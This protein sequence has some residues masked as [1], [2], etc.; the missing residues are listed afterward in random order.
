MHRGEFFLLSVKKKHIILVIQHPIARS[1]PFRHF[2]YVKRHC[3]N[4]NGG[5]GAEKSSGERHRR[6]LTKNG[7]LA[8][9]SAHAKALGDFV[10]A[11]GGRRRLRRFDLRSETMQ[12]V[13]CV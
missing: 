4:E 11:G 12:R 13:K 9:L 7:A 8:G 10:G 1:P 2:F 6:D 3:V 5:G